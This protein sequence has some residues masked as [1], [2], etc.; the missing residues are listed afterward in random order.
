MI[1]TRITAALLFAATIM[2]G[3]N[4]FVLPNGAAAQPVAVFKGDPLTPAG[5]FPA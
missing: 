3:R 1:T 5:T 4:V 2:H